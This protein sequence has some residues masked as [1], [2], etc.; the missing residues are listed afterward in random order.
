MPFDALISLIG[1]AIAAAWTPGPNNAL[2]ANSGARFGFR[3]TLPHVAGIGVGFPFM[4]FCIAV[5]LGQL[6]QQS[7][8]LREAVRIGGVIVL[9]FLAWQIATAD[10][11]T[12][13]K[14]SAKPFSFL[15]AAAF[16]WVNPKAWVMAISISAQYVI[17]D[18]LFATALTVSIVFLVVGFGS[19]SS[20]T[21]FGVGMQRWL[22]TRNRLRLFNFTMAG[23][24]VLSVLFII[25]AELS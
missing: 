18:N 2:V 1:I 11:N 4:I 3:R 21:A 17:S 6:F 24:I 23:L 25:L 7:T 9:L 13:K 16:Q 15:Q 5:G 8:F 20:W 19:A 12:K 14:Q 22:N 10:Q